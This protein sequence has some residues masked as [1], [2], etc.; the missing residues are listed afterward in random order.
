MSTR[1][2]RPDRSRNA[3]QDPR[4]TDRFQ[5]NGSRPAAER[6]ETLEQAKRWDVQKSRAIA[7]GLCVSCASQ[8]A[9]GLQIGFTHSHPP[10]TKCAAIVGA[11]VGEARL[12]GWRNMRLRNVGTADSGERSRAYRSRHATPEKYIE[13]Y[14]TCCC[15]ACWTGYATCHCSGCHHTFVDERTFSRHRIRGR[16][17]DPEARGL[18]K[19][20]RAHW[21]GWGWPKRG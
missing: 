6:P 3:L 16:C 7:H 2:G 18:V 4:A 10:C 17:H 11:T 14:G 9:W 20:T 12:N 5:F 19:I 1:K 21:I 15:G 13:G 8:Y